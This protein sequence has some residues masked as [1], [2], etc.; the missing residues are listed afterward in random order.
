MQFRFLRA[1]KN[2]G[3]HAG[4]F[5]CT[6]SGFWLRVGSEGSQSLLACPQCVPY[7]D[8]NYVTIDIDSF[9]KASG[10]RVTWLDID[11]LLIGVGIGYR[12]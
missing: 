8:V 7:V 3:D 1:N 12:F 5:G 10:A 9:V 11:P 4:G 6:D 2:E